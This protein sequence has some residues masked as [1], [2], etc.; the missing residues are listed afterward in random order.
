MAVG[1]RLSKIM[2][3]FT[4]DG[5]KVQSIQFHS[6]WTYVPIPSILQLLLYVRD[7]FVVHSTSLAA[8]PNNSDQPDGLR[9]LP[10]PAS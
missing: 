9:A 4:P 5:L 3:H 8:E 6:A 1:R 7:N 2:T 10:R